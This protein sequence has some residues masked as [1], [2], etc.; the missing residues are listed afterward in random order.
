MTQIS[1]TQLAKI[2]RGLT[3]K[4]DVFAQAYDEIAW[5]QGASTFKVVSQ[6]AERT[7]GPG[8]PAERDARDYLE[9]LKR[10]RDDGWLVE[11]VFEKF[12]ELAGP[13]SNSPSNNPPEASVRAELH[14]I[15]HRQRRFQEGR[16]ITARS[17]AALRR[18]CILR[19]VRKT[20]SGD[21]DEDEAIGSGFLVGPNLVLTNYHVISGFLE[22]TGSP[23][24]TDDRLYVRF[25]YHAGASEMVK[26]RDYELISGTRSWLLDSSSNVSDDQQET[27]SRF[28]EN[29]DYA[30]L[31][32]DGRPGDMRGYY[33]LARTPELPPLTT[34]VQL[35]QFPRGQTTSM[36]GGEFVSPPASIGFE[37]EIDGHTRIYH[38]CNSLPGA[39]GGLLLREDGEPI[40]LHDAGFPDNAPPDE[41]KNRAVP[42]RHIGRYASSRIDQE[43]AN[44]PP[45]T[46]WHPRRLQPVLGRLKLQQHV[47][48]AAY[49]QARIISVLTSPGD[50]QP[51]LGRTYT[52]TILEA[53][54]PP[55]R[56]HFVTIEA[57]LIDPNPFTT[58]RRIAS[59]IDA[60]LVSRIPQET[61]ETTMDADARVLLVERTV[62]ILRSAAPGKIFWLI[63]DDIDADPI[64]TQ[65]GSSSYLVALYRNIAQSDD[66]RVVL[67]GLP[68]RLEGLRDLY[69]ESGVILEEELQVPPSKQ[70]LKDWVSGHLIDG[71]HPDDFG[72]GLSTLLETIAARDASLAGTPGLHN[73]NDGNGMETDFQ[74][75]QLCPTEAMNRILSKHA[76]RAFQTKVIGN[77]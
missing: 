2:A 45:K 29:L 34:Q 63:I 24:E 56:H 75:D 72:P 32:L 50:R 61:G 49:K 3:V 9:A 71:L 12:P 31:I 4:R 21:D 77:E 30:I 64:G 74:T 19:V 7:S 59:A 62:E 11:F 55:D 35:W 66:L 65:W 1:N 18:C 39:S 73:S 36:A 69:E 60:D 52:R 43:I 22:P 76:R 10:A 28:A 41:Q 70:D 46:G 57:S 23:K 14:S 15:A 6:M 51:K 53:C 67:A 38:T 47:F 20:A 58:A 33:S 26:P 17:L 40:G 27:P 68:R 8:E 13:D 5:A 42:L 37:G 16:R 25:D 48:D 54:L 44:L